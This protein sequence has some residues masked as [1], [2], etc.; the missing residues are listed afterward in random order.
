MQKAWV[1]MLILLLSTELLLKIPFFSS[2]NV[3]KRTMAIFRANM[4][5]NYIG[6]ALHGSRNTK[7]ILATIVAQTNV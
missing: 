5:V 3:G 6:K 7:Q 2:G 1:K 4:G